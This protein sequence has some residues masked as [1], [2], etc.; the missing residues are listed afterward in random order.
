MSSRADAIAAFGRIA[1]IH[2]QAIAQMSPREQA[3]RAW[4]P[5]SSLSVDELEDRIRER[6]GLPALDRQA[7]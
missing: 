7:S 1:A 3:E 2:D 6:R 5:T 4:T